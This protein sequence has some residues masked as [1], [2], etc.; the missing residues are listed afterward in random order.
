[1][2][3]QLGGKLAGPSAQRI[4]MIRS[5]N[6]NFAASDHWHSPGTTTGTN[7]GFT[8]HL[9]AKTQCTFSYF[10]D[11]NNQRRQLIRGRA[12]LLFRGNCKG[13]ENGLAGASRSSETHADSHTWDGISPYTRRGWRL[14]P[15]QWLWG[16]G[17]EGPG[18][19]EA[20]WESAVGPVAEGYDKRQQTQVATW[21]TGYMETSFTP[22]S[23]I[24]TGCPEKM[25]HLHTWRF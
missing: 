5:I 10:M 2:N 3:D 12:E 16:K 19:Q 11:N 24:G 6:S 17:S 22:C 1:M 13:W 4:I 14:M 25:W 15:G 18:G 23:N 20:G 7:T 8:N 9:K 21:E